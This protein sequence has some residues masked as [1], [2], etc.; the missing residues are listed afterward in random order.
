MLTRISHF[1]ERITR[2]RV[3]QLDRAARVRLVRSVQSNSEI[4]FDFV[5]LMCLATLIAALGLVRNSAA[6][7]IGA[8]LVAPL[9][10]PL[11]GCGLALVHGNLRLIRNAARSVLLGFLVSFLI[12]VVLGWAVPVGEQVTDEMLARGSPNLVDLAVAFFSGVAAA[13]ATAR[14]RLSGALP[15]VAIAAA[16]VPPIATCGLAT[17]TGH[18]RL[19]VDALILFLTNITSIVLGASF[20]LWAVG[21]RH[22]HVHSVRKTWILRLAALLVLTVLVLAV[23]L[24]YFLYSAFPDPMAPSLSQ[25]IRTRIHQEAGTSDRD[26]KIHSLRFVE[27]GREVVLSITVS[28]TQPLPAGLATEVARIV[29]GGYPDPVRVRIIDQRVLEATSVSPT[30]P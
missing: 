9:M 15:G 29:Q 2:R 4:N 8:M 13:Y 21:V 30:S 16:L 7:V 26:V 20:A 6:V 23:P 11:V 22:E 27:G 17:A 5:T 12:G 3:P 25:R 28:A 24:G 19:A 14:P 18:P 10:T 1:L